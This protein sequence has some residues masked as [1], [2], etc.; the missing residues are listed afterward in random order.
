MLIALGFLQDLAT[1]ASDDIEYQSTTVSEILQKVKE[2]SRVSP[3][4]EQDLERHK[5]NQNMEETT[6]K[7]TVDWKNENSMAVLQ[8]INDT[9]KLGSLISENEDKGIGN[10]SSNIVSLSLRQYCDDDEVRTRYTEVNGR[11]VGKKTN[12][13]KNITQGS[14]NVESEKRHNAD[15]WENLENFMQ[16]SE[17]HARG[18]LE[19]NGGMAEGE[20]DEDGEEG[21]LWKVVEGKR[22][23]SDVV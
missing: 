20:D 3:N 21:Q 14:P 12:F 7:N 16:A 6:E 5:E 19:R 23:I 10:D 9:S 22:E 2:K 17:N 11:T 18:N 13:I 15:L 8:T 4:P 1:Q